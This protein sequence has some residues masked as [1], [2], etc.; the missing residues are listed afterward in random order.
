MIHSARAFIR[1]GVKLIKQ[2]ELDTSGQDTVEFI[3]YFREL[4]GRIQAAIN[5]NGTADEI[6][7]LNAERVEGL[8][9]D[10]IFSEAI[11][12][13]ELAD[14]EFK[15]GLEHR[16][17]ASRYYHLAMV[18]FQGAETLLGNKVRAMP[19]RLKHTYLLKNRT[20]DHHDYF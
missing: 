11:H 16:K 19:H 5:R 1:H 18:F 14:S 2:F 7:R 13:V 15:K 8:H 17:E 12:Y 3:S 4:E 10:E 6:A 20:T 9:E